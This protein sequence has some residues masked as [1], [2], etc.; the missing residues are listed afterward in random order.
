M[1]ASS[2]FGVN[3]TPS[4]AYITPDTTRINLS[5]NTDTYTS[6]DIDIQNFNPFLIVDGERGKEIH[7][8]DMAPTN[9]ANSEYLGTL[10]DDSNS[11]ISRYYK[12]IN[13]LPWAINIPES[14]S[15]TIEKTQIISGHLKFA[16][17]AESGGT[18]FTDWYQNKS[19]YRNESSIYQLP[20]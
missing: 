2:G 10:H 17:W 8:P 7:L 6:E 5:F 15:Y 9:L 4:E 14:Y 3:V 19:G 20:N 11:G 13:N 18:Q 1:Q 12:T 16:D